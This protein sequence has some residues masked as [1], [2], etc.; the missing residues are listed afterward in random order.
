MITWLQPRHWERRYGNFLKKTNA[1]L[2]KEFLLRLG[3]IIKL[4]TLISY[5]ESL[6]DDTELKA[7]Q[8]KLKEEER[9]QK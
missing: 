3:L 8:E 9:I 1:Q 2:K 6:E 7:N 5:Q 4:Q